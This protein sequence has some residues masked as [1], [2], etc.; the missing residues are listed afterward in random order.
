MPPDECIIPVDGS[1]TEAF[2]ALKVFFMSTDNKIRASIV[3]KGLS[4]I[5]IVLPGVAKILKIR[6][7]LLE[8]SQLEIADGQVCP[9]KQ[10]VG[11]NVVAGDTS[12]VIAGFVVDGCSNYS[13]SQGAHSRCSDVAGDSSTGIEQHANLHPKI[14]PVLQI[15]SQEG[16]KL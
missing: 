10:F 2:Y 4:L 15:R 1:L 7:I 16:C 5:A 9:V 11:I 8:D 13:I 3:S 14:I 6:S 12:R